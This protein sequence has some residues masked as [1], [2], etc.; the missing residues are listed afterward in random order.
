MHLSFEELTWSLTTPRVSQLQA[1]WASLQYYLSREKDLLGIHRSGMLQVFDLLLITDS[2]WD[3][4]IPVKKA[5]MASPLEWA[6]DIL[7][8]VLKAG[9]QLPQAKHCLA[10]PIMRAEDIPLKIHSDICRRIAAYMYVHIVCPLSSESQW[11]LL[12]SQA[13][14]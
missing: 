4:S 9:W 1:Q 13:S 2:A 6:L 7:Q 5:Q 12:R 8:P 11:N 10:A 3:C 14:V